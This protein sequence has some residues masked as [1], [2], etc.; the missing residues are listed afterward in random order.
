MQ[1]RMKAKLRVPEIEKTLTLIEQLKTKRE[2]DEESTID[3]HYNLSDVLYARAEVQCSG[4]VCLWL[5][6]QVMVEFSYAEATEW[7]E[8]HLAQAKER[9]RT[10]AEDLEHLRSNKIMTEVCFLAWQASHT[11]RAHL[12]HKPIRSQ[13]WPLPEYTTTTSRRRR[14]PAARAHRERMGR[15]HLPNTRLQS[16]WLMAT[17]PSVAPLA[18]RMHILLARDQKAL[19]GGRPKASRMRMKNAALLSRRQHRDKPRLAPTTDTPRAAHA[20]PR[21]NARTTARGE[22]LSRGLG[23][24]LA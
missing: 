13:R 11:A 9:I 21:C 4:T 20:N 14:R 7:L 17:S 12:S 5:G 10:T 23:L 18:L 6:A 16:P 8:R 19:E 2:E 1:Q 15:R 3:T 24:G 22:T